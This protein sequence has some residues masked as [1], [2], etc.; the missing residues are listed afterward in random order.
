[1]NGRCFT[2]GAQAQGSSLF[3]GPAKVAAEKLRR[4]SDSRAVGLAGAE[5]L[6][7][8]AKLN[9]PAKAVPLLQSPFSE[10]FRKL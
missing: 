5:A 8:L 6:I 4:D 1:M 10:F 3:H 7:H 9:G 2:S